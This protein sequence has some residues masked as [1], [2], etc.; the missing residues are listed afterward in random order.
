MYI[1]TRLRI[2]VSIS[3]SI[4]PDIPQDYGPNIKKLEFWNHL[5]NEITSGYYVVSTLDFQS[6]FLIVGQLSHSILTTKVHFL[7]NS[8][9]LQSIR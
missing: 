3:S 9:S 1:S 5:E 6:S 2:C 7:K 4:H 8:D